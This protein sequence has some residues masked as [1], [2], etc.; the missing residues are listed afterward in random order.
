MNYKERAEEIATGLRT[1]PDAGQVHAR[2]RIAGRDWVTFIERMVVPGTRRVAG[3]TVSRL[4][5]R[6]G[7]D[8]DG[9]SSNWLETWSLLRYRGLH[10]ETESEFD[11]QQDLDL[12]VAHFLKNPTFSWGVVVG[13]LVLRVIEERLYGQVVCHVAECDLV[14][15][16][17]LSAVGDT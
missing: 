5:A 2:T 4:S 13:E 3:W 12:A 1:L 10:D 14:V 15:M 7:G 6:Q 17:D 9:A 8:E 11:F 16:M